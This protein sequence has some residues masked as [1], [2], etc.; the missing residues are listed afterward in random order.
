MNFDSPNTGDD[1]PGK[2][3]RCK[4]SGRDPLHAG[5]CQKCGGDGKG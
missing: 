3:T 2:C 1:N 5:A 4:G